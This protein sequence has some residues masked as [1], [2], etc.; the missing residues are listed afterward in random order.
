MS[1]VRTGAMSEASAAS[2]RVVRHLLVD[3]LYHWLMAIAVLLLMGTAFL[4]ILGIKFAVGGHPLDDR[5][6]TRRAGADP[7]QSAR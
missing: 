1:E 3:R 5:R 6:D 2:G 7:Y 4:P